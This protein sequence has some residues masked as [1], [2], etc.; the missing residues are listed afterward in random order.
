[1]PRAIGALS[2]LEEPRHRRHRILIHLRILEDEAVI[3]MQRRF[4]CT[5]R[6]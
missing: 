6:I 5:P 2:G 3:A 1:M 4:V